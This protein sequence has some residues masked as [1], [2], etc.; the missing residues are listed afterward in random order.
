MQSNR[1]ALERGQRLG[2]RPDGGRLD[3]VVADEGDD[4][5]EL[6][7]VVLDDEQPLDR[8]LDE[9]VEP[10]EGVVERLLGHGLLQE[11]QGPLLQAALTALGGGDDVDGDV[12]GLR[13][14]LEAVEDRPPVHHRELDVEDD[15]VGRL[16]AGHGQAHVALQ[17]DEAPE[18]LLAGQ[19]EQEPREA[20]VVLDDQDD[21]VSLPDGV[22]VV[23]D[24]AGGGH[25]LVHGDGGSGPRP[26]RRVVAPARL[27]VPPARPDAPGAAGAGRPRRP[28]SRRRGPGA[29]RPGAG[30][31]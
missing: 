7:L 17:G 1:S 27:A 3:V 15:G 21:A 6:R 11:G 9:G 29:C 30:R 25:R 23:V 26:G 14:V 24:R 22:A 19:V 16:L 31:A 20:D 8:P 28:G 4:A 13:V 10:G 5:V 18:A 2:A 12:A